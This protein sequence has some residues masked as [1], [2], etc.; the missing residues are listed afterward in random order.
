M[1]GVFRYFFR[2]SKASCASLIHWNLSYF[3]EEFEEMKSPDTES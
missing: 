1:D 3:F 2:S